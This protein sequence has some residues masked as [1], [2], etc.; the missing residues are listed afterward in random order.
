MKKI[1]A[2][3]LSICFLSTMVH[4]SDVQPHR[5]ILSDDAKATLKRNLII[6]AK[7]QGT[8]SG[9]QSVNEFLDKDENTDVSVMLFDRDT[10]SVELTSANENFNRS[11]GAETWAWCNK[12]QF[13]RLIGEPTSECCC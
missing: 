3:T 7:T 13:A 2:L 5:I 4:S 6:Y 8:W 10:Y 1:L 9:V 12:Q 11:V